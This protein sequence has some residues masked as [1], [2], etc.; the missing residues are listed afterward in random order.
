MK[1]NCQTYQEW[2]APALMDELEP[3]R[4]RDLEDHIAD[5]ADCRRERDQLAHTLDLMK[6]AGEEDV[7]HHFFVE[8]PA[9]SMSPWRMF[10]SLPALWRTALAT[11]AAL[12][13]VSGALSISSFQMR[14]QEGA[15]V[16]GFGE[17]PDP[18]SSG[19]LPVEELDAFAGTLLRV[20]DERLANQSEDIRLA[21]QEEILRFQD[22][23]RADNAIK[24]QQAASGLQADLEQRL[25]LQK[26]LAREELKYQLRNT[27]QD[28]RDQY[29]IDLSGIGASLAEFQRYSEMQDQ[30]MSALSN[31]YFQLTSAGGEEE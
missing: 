27:L 2:I 22:A 30:R 20:V 10:K 21:W 6:G 7:P 4:Q 17:L 29:E 16:A 14:V 12:L 11:S 13:L 9:V 18:S 3:A 25:Q 26:G 1:A 5:C 19:R 24:W 31:A 8:P 28:W 15:V 23:L